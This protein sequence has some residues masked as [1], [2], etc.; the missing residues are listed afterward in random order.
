MLAFPTVGTHTSIPLLQ[1]IWNT[2]VNNIF[3]FL[4]LFLNCPK[5]SIK[6]SSLIL[7]LKVSGVDRSL[8]IIGQF[9]IHN[10]QPPSEIENCNFQ[11]KA[12]N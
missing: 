10:K 7:I 9:T 11:S 3:H 6:D 2:R 8:G 4:N 12:C 1:K 5:M